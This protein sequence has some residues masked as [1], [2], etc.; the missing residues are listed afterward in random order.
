MQVVYETA[1]VLS[2]LGALARVALE[3]RLDGF[4]VQV[5]G[6][7]ASRLRSPTPCSQ[8]WSGEKSI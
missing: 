2:A 5:E 3:E 4:A 1:A 8:S 7:T 6:K